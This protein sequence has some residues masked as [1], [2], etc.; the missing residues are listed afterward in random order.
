MSKVKAL[1]E[2]LPFLLWGLGLTL[3]IAEKGLW[4]DSDKDTDHL[5]AGFGLVT[6][7]R[8]GWTVRPVTRM[9]YWFTDDVPS[10]WNEFDPK[11][12]YLIKFWFPFCPYL[13]LAFLQ[14]GFYMGFK[15]FDLQK[16]KYAALVGAENI[17]EGNQ[18]L[19]PS[20]T[21]RRTRWK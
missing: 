18:A 5:E 11:Y 8:A 20:F 17:G 13:S 14:Y 16:D 19:T 21:I 15:A 1:L 6:K 3:S 2:K 4:Y 12:H 7:V 9:K 10:K